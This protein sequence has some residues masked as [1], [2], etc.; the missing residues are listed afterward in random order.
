MLFYPW[1]K[2]S[3]SCIQLKRY[4]LFWILLLCSKFAF[5]YFVQVNFTL[6]YFGKM[7]WQDGSDA[8]T[9]LQ[10]KPLI[11]PTK[12]IMNVHNIHYEWHEFFPNGNQCL[13]LG[14]VIMYFSKLIIAVVFSASYNVGAVM[15]LWAPVLLVWAYPTSILADHS[16]QWGLIIFPGSYYSFPFLLNSCTKS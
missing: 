3:F 13:F 11:K 6:G 12:D 4:T 10:I 2:N 9:N 5:S 16:E 7:I 14:S 8:H 15:S 1:K